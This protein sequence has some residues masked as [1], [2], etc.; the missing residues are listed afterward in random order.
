[1]FS[2]YLRRNNGFLPFRKVPILNILRFTRDNNNTK[3]ISTFERKCGLQ[4]QGK[5]INS[6]LSGPRDIPLIKLTLGQLLQQAADR[7]GDRTAAVFIHQDI[8]K[9]FHQVLVDADKA[10]AGLRS[11]GLKRGDRIGIWGPNSYEWLLTQ[12]AAARIG[13][14]LVN[15]NPAYQ[16]EELRYVLE[17]VGVKALVV[18]KHF[19]NTNLMDILSQLV[20]QLD[21]NRNTN[22]HEDTQKPLVS[23]YLIPT[24][25]RVIVMSDEPQNNGVLRWQDLMELASTALIAEIHN[26]QRDIQ[27]DDAANIQFTSGT[28]GSPK[29]ATLSHNNI[30]NNS[31]NV[32]LRVGYHQKEH[33]ICVPVPLY[34]C[35][36]C[37][38]AVLAAAS[39]GAACVFPSPVFSA[40]EAVKAIHHE[41]CTSLYGTPTMFVDILNLPDLK[42]YDLKSLSTGIMAGAPCPEEIAKG[43]IKDLNMKDFA[44]LYGMTECSPA[45]FMT[46]P[47]DSFDLRCST[48]G[49][50]GEHVEVKIV[51]PQTNEVVPINTPGEICTRGYNTMLGYWN[52]PDKTSEIISEDGWIRS[53]DLGVLN[54]DGY[55]KIVGRIKDMI[56]RGGENVYPR[57]IEE[58]LHAH[59]SV[60][61]AQVV[62]VPDERLGEEICAWIRCKPQT[63]LDSLELKKF[64]SEKM[65]YFKVP[66]YWM[67]KD[68]FPLTVTGK[69]K[70]FV[71][72]DISVKELGL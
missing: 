20:P 8:R 55:G 53:G 26:L 15:I 17:K 37:G 33:K 70:K 14:I 51:D 54:E 11:L 18:A 41:R 23:C 1:M 56:I 9:T 19:R 65:A 59:P 57:E 68:K 47:N 58:I 22:Q 32:G 72:R 46:L 35:F 7:F 3:N 60:Q 64:C 12:W 36:G 38:L 2:C 61:E 21:P 69:V 66:K 67:F 4:Q 24:L 43:T 48:I 63:H 25:E 39:F 6:Y 29:G 52:Q 62:G 49:Y 34:H 28:T 50:P 16:A 42:Q 44:I 45:T 31:Y 10:A 27:V 13:L 30:V 5:L 40:R 71:M